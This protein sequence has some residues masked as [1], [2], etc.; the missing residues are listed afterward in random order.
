MK[1]REIDPPEKNWLS[2]YKIIDVWN[3]ITKWIND[4]PPV[5]RLVS[6]AV[7]LA[8]FITVTPNDIWLYL[9]TSITAEGTIVSMVLVFSLVALSLLWSV[10]QRIDVWVFT[11]FNM[12]GHRA[13]SLDRVML[14]FSQI[15]NGIFAMVIALVLFINVNH[16]LA[17]ELAL[18]TLSL[19]LVVD[20]IKV[21]VHRTRPYIKLENSRIVGSKASGC[22]FPSGHT[23]QAF[24]MATLLLHYFQGNASLWFLLYSMAFLVGITRIYVGM[25]Y[26]RDV[27]GGSILGTA[28]GLI[29][30]IVNSYIGNIG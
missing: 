11:A 18:G 26:P 15:G 9:W 17:Y 30:V 12:L 19:W 1:R 6:M 5:Y 8:V 4:I 21:L 29:G 22:S 2:A 28:W 24:F 3:T 25:H 13:P 10:G 20:L 27:M 7:S 14:G 23:S 16:L